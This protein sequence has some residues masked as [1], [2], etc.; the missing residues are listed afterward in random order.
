MINKIHITVADYVKHN[1]KVCVQP[2]SYVLILT[3]YQIG[4]NFCSYSNQGPLCV[5]S[6]IS[7]FNYICLIL[8]VINSLA[9]KRVIS[10]HLV[11]LKWIFF[12]VSQRYEGNF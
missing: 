8:A 5:Y 11:Y 12:T 4:N 7:N 3:V 2:S 6:T 10:L 9:L 1:T